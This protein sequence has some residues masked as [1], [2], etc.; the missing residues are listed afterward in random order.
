MRSQQ[1][2]RADGSMLTVRAIPLVFTSPTTV[3]WGCSKCNAASSKRMGSRGL[4]LMTSIAESAKCDLTLRNEP[5][6]R[7]TKLEETVKSYR[8]D[9]SAR[10]GARQHWLER[11]KARRVRSRLANCET[12]KQLPVI[13]GTGKSNRAK[14]G[15]P[16]GIN[17]G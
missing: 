4:N 15:W 8:Q 12:D 16:E 13:S 11:G 5:L 6:K 1:L 10:S 9:F 7:G 17:V 2:W 14:D 3:F